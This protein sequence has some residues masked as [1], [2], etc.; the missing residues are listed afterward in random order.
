[1]E[2]SLGQRWSRQGNVKSPGLYGLGHL[3]FL[4]L[5]AAALVG[6]L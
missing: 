1:M 6:R 2:A 5:E 4:Q 3:S